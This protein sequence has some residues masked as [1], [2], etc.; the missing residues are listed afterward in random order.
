MNDRPIWVIKVGGSLAKNG[1]MTEDLRA[2]L[3]VLAVTDRRRCSLVI[4]PG[5]GSYADSAR[6][7]GRSF[8]LSE[9]AGHDLA[10]R[11][12]ELYGFFLSHVDSRFSCASSLQGMACAWRQ[13]RHVIWLPSAMLCC[14][15]SLCPLPRQWAYTSDSLALWLALWLGAERLFWVKARPPYH[16]GGYVWQ[17]QD[18]GLLDKGVSFFRHR[19]RGGLCCFCLTAQEH[20]KWHGM[21]MGGD[22]IGVPV[23]WEQQGAV[24]TSR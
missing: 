7:M 1:D 8:S 12:M 23:L 10:V 5:G 16:M 20:D 17:L 4:V 9:E 24:M 14:E 18:E 22:D 21:V 2:W 3:S 11:G 15:E 19:E 6:H 13:G